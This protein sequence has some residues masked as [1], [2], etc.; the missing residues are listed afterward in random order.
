M[1][2]ESI[3]CL[4]LDT[5]KATSFFTIDLSK[6]LTISLKS[7]L[8]RRIFV[9]GLASWNYFLRSYAED[10]RIDLVSFYNF[11]LVLIKGEY[12]WRI[13]TDYDTI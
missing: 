12:Q 5:I 2:I 11:E 13:D 6:N 10:W 4:S 9:E 7:S 8:D 1:K 3:S